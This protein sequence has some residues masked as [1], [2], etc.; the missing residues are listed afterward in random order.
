[1]D[2]LNEA[3]LPLRRK[4]YITILLGI[5]CMLLGEALFV[6][7]DDKY[8]LILSFVIFCLSLYR[9]GCIYRTITKGSYETIEGRCT[10]VMP[11]VLRKY[12]K[13]RVMDTNGN[14]ST[15]LLDKRSIIKIG[16]KY[17]FYFRSTQRMTFGNT[18]LDSYLPLDYFLGYEELDLPDKHKV[19]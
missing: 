8:M 2:K 4:F 12:C 1:M 18:Y 6:I 14:E 7:I 13:I 17:R 16:H 10:A 15:L 9:A 19:E 5:L 11:K 3:P